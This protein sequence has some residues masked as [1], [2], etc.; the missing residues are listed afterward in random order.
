MFAM[1]GA[2]DFAAESYG[3]CTAQPR[4]RDGAGQRPQVRTAGRHA[5]VDTLTPR[6]LAGTCALGI[7]LGVVRFDFAAVGR[8]MI[9]SGW[10]EP[11]AI[12]RLAGLNL[13]GYLL[14]CLHQGTVKHPGPLRRMLALALVM[15]L[16]SLWL[17]ALGKGELWQGFW[18]FWA[19]WGAGH[20]MTGL[21]S[22]ALREVDASLRRRATSVVMAGAGLGGILGALSIGTLTPRSPQGAWLVLAA[23]STL[24]AMPVAWL[25]SRRDDRLSLPRGAI[26]PPAPP[27]AAAIGGEARA[28]LVTLAGGYL[29]VGAAQVP[30]VLYEPL[31]ISRRLGADPA[32][33]SDSL[34]ILGAG[35]AA[36]ALLAALLPRSWPSRTLLPLA[37]LI[38]WL[39]S[40]L[41]MA[42][43]TFATISAGSFLVGFWIWMVAT[44]TYDRLQDLVPSEHHR[45]HWA[46][47]TALLALGF[48]LCSFAI[49][50]L[51]GD[52]LD[53]IPRLGVGLMAIH[54]LLEVA[55]WRPSRRGRPPLSPGRRSAA[56][57]CPPD[58]EGRDPH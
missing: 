45:R 15:I 9:H 29:L 38:G 50:P 48:M 34:S 36:G 44:L 1:E 11:A 20:L 17:E 46:S 18:R 47:L 52:R 14:G 43:Q 10:L 41:F 24:L 55:Q 13:A 49:A 8:Q 31:L 32:V 21:P 3:R 26:D 35:C 23:V 27:P 56:P 19:G 25:L 16:L 33:S 22:L 30:V 12:G 28:S 5:W 42:G 37:A 57:A 53:T 40:L 6:V 54:G 39:G 7:G 58:R 4:R 51:A 2:G